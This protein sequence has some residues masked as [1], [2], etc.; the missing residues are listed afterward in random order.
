MPTC[1]TKPQVNARR[2]PLPSRGSRVGR[3]TCGY[4]RPSIDE[5]EGVNKRV[6]WC[7]SGKAEMT[8][9]YT[10]KSMGCRL[11]PWDIRHCTFWAGMIDALSDLG[12]KQ[13]ARGF[14]RLFTSRAKDIATLLWRGNLRVPSI[15]VP[16]QCDTHARCASAGMALLGKQR[17]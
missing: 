6:Y 11:A 1:Q 16:L 13:Q 8:R 9:A 12:R 14:T 5:K 4:L 17:I 10:A 15:H 3:D 2:S 7:C